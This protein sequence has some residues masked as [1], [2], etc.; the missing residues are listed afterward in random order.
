MKSYRQKRDVI[1]K[2]RTRAL[3]RESL[4]NRLPDKMKVDISKA[5]KT[6][7]KQQKTI[8]KIK[9]EKHKYNWK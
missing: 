2:R 7:K 9:H 8:K 3:R 5:M 1:R 6:Y 4:W